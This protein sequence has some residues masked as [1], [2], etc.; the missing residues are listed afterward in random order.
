M[1]KKITDDGLSLF[2]YLADEPGA[3]LPTPASVGAPHGATFAPAGAVSAP[4]APGA[5]PELGPTAGEK[6]RQPSDQVGL[7]RPTITVRE[8][9]VEQILRDQAVLRDDPSY[10]VPSREFYEERIMM[11]KTDLLAMR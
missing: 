8:L 3:P 6:E 10:W 4:K 1:P 9:Y 2:D 7:N 11:Y 5:L